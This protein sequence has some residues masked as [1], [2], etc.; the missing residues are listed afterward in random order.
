M[1]KH[2]AEI[3]FFGKTDIG[4]Q[5][6][7]NEDAF[8]AQYMWDSNHIL[9]VAIDGVGGYDGGE[10]AA[11]IAQ[12]KIVEYLDKYPNGE[13]LEL[14]KQAVTFANN[15]IVEERRKQGNLANMSCVL[16]AILIEVEKRQINMVHVGDTRLYQYHNGDLKKLSHDHSPVGYREEIGALTEKEAMQHPQ[17]NII[18]RDVG[19]A[20]HEVSDRDFLETATFPLLPN[21]I[22]W[23]CSDGLS[24]MITSAQMKDV[25]QQE[26]SLEEKVNGVI[27]AANAAGGKD[28]ITVVMIENQNTESV[29]EENDDRSD[30]I[31]TPMV[32]KEELSPLLMKTKKPRSM[33]T[34]IFTAITILLLGVILGWLVNEKYNSENTRPI[35]PLNKVEKN[36]FQIST[37]DSLLIINKTDTLL[38]N[39][40][41]PVILEGV[42]VKKKSLEDETE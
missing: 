32:I 12:Q 26:I 31:E 35:K 17:R 18:N 27:D 40:E 14:L 2:K 34:K 41:L 21:S 16:S 5:R 15:S 39:G 25:L 30:L 4:R 33:L 29:Q 6:T 1:T 38:I 22:I 28:N 19:S 10:I 23:L 24:D 9:A 36:L 11:Q 7:N 8:V 13:R 37:K 3:T 42:W 20:H